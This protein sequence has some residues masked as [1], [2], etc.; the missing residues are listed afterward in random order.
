MIDLTDE[1][2]IKGLKESFKYSFSGVQ[3]EDTLKFLE[4][5]CGFWMGGPATA[6]D[7]Q[8]HALQ[9]ERGKR[10]VILTLK[11]IMNEEWSP[12]QIAAMYK[13]S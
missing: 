13:R 2:A 10:D 5:F 6:E 3:G 7:L 1:I 12:K 4:Q 9:Y 8:A 11:T